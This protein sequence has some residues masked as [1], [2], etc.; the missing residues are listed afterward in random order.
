MEF[1]CF[2]LD[3]L[4][5]VS[6]NLRNYKT[7]NNYKISHY[8]SYDFFPL[9][10]YVLV[11]LIL[12]YDVLF[13]ALL[14]FFLLGVLFLYL[15]YYER[16]LTHFCSF[17]KIRV[18]VG[19]SVFIRVSVCRTFVLFYGIFGEDFTQFLPNGYGTFV[20]T[21]LALVR[22]IFIEKNFNF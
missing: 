21:K 17:V 9:S 20:L 7:F 10:H 22:D 19:I 8:H 6:L 2:F 4:L 14:I 11:F 5:L 12:F 15:L 18:F 3:I 13:L 1:Y 16:G